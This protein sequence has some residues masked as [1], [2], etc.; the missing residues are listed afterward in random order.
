MIYFN[1]SGLSYT[2]KDQIGQVYENFPLY[3]Q[4]LQTDMQRMRLAIL[5]KL[6]RLK[7]RLKVTIE[8]R[9]KVLSGSLEPAEI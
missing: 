2:V 1:Q 6:R 7:G 3:F 4:T 9:A 5:N 8:F